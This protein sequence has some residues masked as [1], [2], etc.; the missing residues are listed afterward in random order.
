VRDFSKAA[1]NCKEDVWPLA[2]SEISKMSS[3]VSP[4]AVLA[5]SCGGEPLFVSCQTETPVP[6]DREKERVEKRNL[7]PEVKIR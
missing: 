5:T 7:F 6:K 1:A 3:R 4:R 2:G